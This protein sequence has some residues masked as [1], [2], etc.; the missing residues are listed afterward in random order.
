ML[1]VLL[2]NMARGRVHIVFLTYNRLDYTRRSLE[3]LL[4]DPTECFD[5]TIWDNASTDGTVE[6]LRGLRPDPRIKDV[7]F[8][9]KNVG[10][11]YAVNVIWSASKADLVGKVDNDC[12][13][14]PGWTRILARAHVDIPELGVVACWHFFPD[15]FYEESARHKIHRYG[16]HF[17]FRHPWTCGSG[18]LVKRETY[19]K[20]GPI[21]AGAMTSYFLRMALK[22]YVN[23]FYYPPIVQ[24]HMDDPKSP[25]SFLKDEESYQK[26]KELTYSLKYHGQETLADRWRWRKNVID[27]LHRGS[28]DARFY[29]KWHTGFF[30]TARRLIQW[31]SKRGSPSVIHM[32]SDS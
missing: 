17:I 6:F 16:N 14:T 24:E 22:G 23:G 9:K 18:F 29:V 15:D 25:Y 21:T 8:S 3:R 2:A 5:L 11:T 10:Q 32:H 12:L 4:S 26:A 20:F 28:L 31:V 13:V 1:S 27:V 7:V 30:K 19:T